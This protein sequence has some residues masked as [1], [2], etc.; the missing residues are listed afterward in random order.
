MGI[1]A[2]LVIVVFGAIQLIPVG[3]T[4]PPV[5]REPVW[6]APETRRLAQSACLDCHSNTTA[7]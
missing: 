5:G 2:V 6:D 7:G 3:R 4:N 1:N